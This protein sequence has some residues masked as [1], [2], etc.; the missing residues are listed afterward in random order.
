MQE[1]ITLLASD[2][3]L[4]RIDEL[5]DQ[6]CN[7]YSPTQL[8]RILN[9]QIMPFFRIFTHVNVIS[10]VLLRGKAMTV[11]HIMYTSDGNGQRAISLFAALGTHLFNTCIVGAN[12]TNSDDG[13]PT[14]EDLETI[15]VI[16]AVLSKLIEVNTPA[17]ANPGLIPIAET[18]AAL[19]DSLPKSTT[20]AMSKAKKNFERVQR[21]AF[22]DALAVQSTVEHPCDLSRCARDAR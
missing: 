15:E 13:E 14:N 20:F 3:G 7:I 16:L 18:F 1:V 2:C 6:P 8:T 10:S 17:H 21:Q 19:L 11:Y 5:L 4:L 22:P 12:S 9:D